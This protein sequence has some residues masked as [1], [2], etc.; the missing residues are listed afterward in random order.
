VGRRHI[1][2]AA[3]S[4]GL[5]ATT[6]RYYE[7]R[8]TIPPPDRTANGY[9]SYTDR[10]VKRLT[11]V[12]RAR[13]LDLPAE[14]L[15]ELVRVWEHDRCAPVADRLSGMVADRLADTQ[16]R[17]AELTALAGQLQQVHDQLDR[18]AHDGPCEDGDC[19]CLDGPDSPPAST[20]LPIAPDTAG[21]GVSCTLDPA[22]MPGRMSAWRDLL[23]QATDRWPI[24]GGVAVRF[25]NFGDLAT[26]MVD[27]ASAEHNC[28]NF[29]TFSVHVTT[30]HLDLHVTGPDAAQ[31]TITT[32]F[33]PT[34]HIAAT[35]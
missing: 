27:L 26:K 34:G 24:A 9:R 13:G 22:H 12:A 6:I 4:S 31:P 3:A 1:A 28:C 15:T 30:D 18:P 8:G 19:I 35:N 5:P 17:I 11:F 14:D 32:V 33:G 2:Q 10:D 21:D 25:P 23:E 20:P 7:D 16:D 29:F